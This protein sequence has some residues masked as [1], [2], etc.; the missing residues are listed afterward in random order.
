[1][2]VHRKWP[3]GDEKTQVES[4]KDRRT[5]VTRAR[6]LAACAKRGGER[7]GE[8][9]RNRNTDRRKAIKSGPEFESGP[10]M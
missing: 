1:M 10:R 9:E 5:D 2:A 6:H 4:V 8:G 3:V 7:K